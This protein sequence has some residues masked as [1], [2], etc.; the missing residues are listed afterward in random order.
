MKRTVSAGFVGRV[1]LT[2]LGL[3]VLFHLLVLAGAVPS[4]DVWGGRR[5]GAPGRLLIMKLLLTA[6]L[7]TRSDGSNYRL[8]ARL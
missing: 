5:A 4:D 7:P 2:A 3:L 8:L 6:F 1:L